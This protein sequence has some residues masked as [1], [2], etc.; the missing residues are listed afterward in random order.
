MHTDVPSRETLAQQF[1]NPPPEYGFYPGWW[2]EGERV[3]RE[4]L[5]WQLEEMKKVGTFATFFYVRYMGDEPFAIAPAYGS[6]E[7]LDL[8]RHSLEEHRRLGMQ[9]YFSEWTG[10]RSVED[11]IARDPATYAALAGSRLVLHERE[12]K[13]AG[14][15]EVEIPP[16]E[17]VLSAAAYK[18]A[19]GALDAASRQDLADRITD[20]RLRWDAPEA[21]WVLTVVTSQTHGL[22]YLR[23]DVA[24]R[25]VERVW[26]PYL[27]KVPEF[28]GTTFKGY[29]QDE[30]DVL[31]GHI[32]YSTGLLER[33]TAEKGYDPR[34][35]LV[36]LFHDIGPRTDKIRCEYHETVAK[37]LEENVYARL[38]R[39]HEDRGMQ[40][41]TIAVRGRQDMLAE[42]GNFGDLFRLL[43]WYHFPG[44]EDPHVTPTTPRL[45]RIIDAK[46]S[47][48]AAHIFERQRAGL[49]AY[50]GAG[51]GMT[52]EQNVAWTNEN[53]AYGMNLY[54]PHLAA[55]S[56]G[57]G[58]YEWVPPAH[59]FHS[60][61]WAH[62]KTF[63]DYVRRLSFVM[64]QGVH[65]ADL[66][67]LFPTTSIH[68]NWLRGDSFTH[69]ADVTA[70]ST[71]NMA[72]TIYT[73]GVDFD[74]IDEQTLSQA[75]VRGGKLCVSG[76]EFRAV[77]L[78]PMTTIHIETLRKLKELYDAGGIV[79]AYQG[80]PTA[81][82][83]RG[84]G[85]PEV[86]ALLE[87]MF[88]VGSAEEHTHATFE[89]PDT[90][91]DQFFASIRATRSPAGGTGLFVPGEQN[92]G[93]NA[94]AIDLPA[95]L[96]GAMQ[97]DVSAPAGDVFHTHQ[98]VGDLDVYFLYNASSETRELALTFRVEGEPELWD[99]SSGRIRPL[100]RFERR[101][102]LTD[103]RLR[104]TRHQ[105][106]ILSFAPARGRPEAI[107]DN[108]AEL[109]SVEPHAG[110]VEVRGTCS[111][112]GKKEVRV[113][114]DGREY[115]G[116]ARVDAP[117]DPVLLGGEWRFR[118]KPTM[119]NRWGDFRHPAASEKIG[120]EARTFK[121]MEEAGTAGSELGWHE[122][123]CDDANWPQ[124]VASFGPYWH[125]I[126][127][128][129]QGEE[130]SALLESAAA[131]KSALDQS[132]E[133]AGQT[134]HW[135]RYDFSQ[136]YGHGSKEVHQIWGG[137][138]GVSDCFLVFD[139]VPGGSDV[140]R[141]LSTVVH[142]PADG[143]W[144]LVVGGRGQFARQAWV[145][146]RQM[147]SV[148]AA[149]EAT[150]TEEVLALP[151]F[152][153]APPPED[154][155]EISDTR[156]KVRLNEGPN[157]VVLRLVQPRGREVYAYAVLLRPGSDPSAG[158]P[159][160][161]RLRWF[162]ESSGLTYDVQPEARQ[163]VGWYRF[164]APAGVRA[165]TLQL[166][167]LDVTAWVD[168][169]EMAVRDGRIELD[170]PS[171]RVCRV[172][173]RIE[174]KPGRYAG[175]A[176]PEPVSFECEEARMPLGDWCDHALECYSGGAVYSR[177][178]TLEERH[179]CGQVLLDLGNAM[180]T[181]EVRVNGAVVGVG[182]A[183]PFEFDITEHVRAG[184]NELE[185]EVY[186]TL[187]NHYSQGTPSRFV[188]EGQTVSG[189]LGPV[190]LNFRRSIALLARPL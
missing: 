32:V 88:G 150:A 5:T 120:A 81:S 112:G 107:A 8:F 132:Y 168:G 85:D 21:G 188:Y 118:L 11:E 187:A 15:L 134:F 136:L 80:L 60:P 129:P 1:T 83:E 174:Q 84:R 7:F 184:D 125:S 172:A 18:K 110:H 20:G 63:G 56:M 49:C 180:V 95:I 113:R 51:W 24:D 78:P 30:L 149:E 48:S 175:A 65:R 33:F 115:V 94:S 100:H 79:L 16:D 163:R 52:M 67:I 89:P 106:T 68:A 105:G 82:A 159:P 26:G 189:L 109:V 124:H 131:G 108:L 160:I 138:A 133:V 29:V 176:I 34:P 182:L 98:K 17:Q 103:V 13:G 92:S 152:E 156:V 146:G 143:E 58:W 137:L 130:P 190:T 28:I 69:A 151:R 96:A 116:E 72:R 101:G 170:A 173:L 39:W 74:F 91:E 186:N 9:A 50:W 153:Q 35:E 177:R 61:Y 40:Y 164:E 14:R 44:N 53:Y 70:S 12:A 155:E 90:H 111:N 93:T 158:R 4:K 66:A 166:D 121:Y 19:S 185:V 147:L 55:Y 165:I 46:L 114:H 2:W 183:R 102:P 117:P 144:D 41:G 43:R 181:A 22:D 140:S 99:A 47:S 38:S 27:A 75:E 169:R 179:L 122:R 3:T 77:A 23:P 57:G 37:L 62:Y 42:T 6:D 104:M 167:A 157:T 142:A 141:Y 10:Q 59:F 135:Q 36:G 31:S 128:F 119:D 161:P 162:I 171:P 123:E 145:N 139:D 148:E 45:R 73:G 126:G 71:Y 127:P 54:D 76:L 178:F 87:A 25:W 97:P 86:R 64:S 154:L